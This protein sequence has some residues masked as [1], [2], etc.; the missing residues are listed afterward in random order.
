MKSFAG[1]MAFGTFFKKVWNGVK[2]VAKKVAP[3][4]QKGLEIAGK[5]APV[6]SG[7]VTGMGHPEVGQAIYKGGGIAERAG[8][9]IG[10]IRD[11][12]YAGVSGASNLIRDGKRVILGENGAGQR[13]N[14]PVLK[15]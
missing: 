14:Q 4:L 10:D 1:K 12:K 7:I 13:F 9:V 6:V 3:V 5:I 11:G 8:K 15:G 2:N